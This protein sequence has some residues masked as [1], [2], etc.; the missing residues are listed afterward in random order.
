MNEE[1]RTMG[2]LVT[3][4]IPAYN[5]EKT[6]VRCMQS[7]LEQ[8]YKNVEVIIIDDGS[9]DNTLSGIQSFIEENQLN[10]I[11]ISREN[12]GV[13]YT[14]NE[15]IKLSKGDYIAFLDSDDYWYNEKLEKQM[16]F[17]ETYHARIVGGNIKNRKSES[18]SQFYSQYALKD[19]LLSNRLF[20]S[21]VLLEKNIF[22]EVGY[23]NENM[24]YSEDYNLWLRIATKNKIYVINEILVH[25]ELDYSSGLSS[26][27]YE[28][29]KGELFN[30][31]TLYKA[32]DISM[33]EFGVFSVISCIK[34]L[35]RLCIVKRQ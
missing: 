21:T 27:L 2:K 6:I 30:F 13:S 25:Y 34:F 12:K 14:R 18:D 23:F 22:Q 35:K 7:V 4:I 10:W 24:L 5:A 28:M 9:S 26:K 32:K 20:T 31:Y 1:V 19:M 16:N 29:E 33:I 17:I 15:G 8:T 3:V 11:L